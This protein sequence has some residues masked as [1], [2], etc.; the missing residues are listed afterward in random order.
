MELVTPDIGRPY[1]RA[2]TSIDAL[3]LTEAPPGNAEGGSNSF[4]K[5][6]TPGIEPGS[7]VA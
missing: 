3:A 6:E 2:I 5:V 7:A 1:Y 4:A